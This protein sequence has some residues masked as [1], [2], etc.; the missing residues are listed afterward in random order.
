MIPFPQRAE[1]KLFVIQVFHGISQIAMEILKGRTEKI[2]GSHFYL[3]LPIQFNQKMRESFAFPAFAAMGMPLHP[4]PS[5]VFDPELRPKGAHDEA[6]SPK[7]GGE[8][9][10]EGVF[11][12]L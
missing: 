6:L 10:G 3:L 12:G 7:K 8:G 4:I 9:E 11:S 1:V 5:A 2:K